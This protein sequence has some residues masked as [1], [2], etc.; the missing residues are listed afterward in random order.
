MR[1]HMVARR[2]DTGQSQT[3]TFCGIFIYVSF[4]VSFVMRIR[5]CVNLLLESLCNDELGHC[6]DGDHDDQRQVYHLSENNS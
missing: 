2:G 5:L 1:I 6:H 4:N 3:L